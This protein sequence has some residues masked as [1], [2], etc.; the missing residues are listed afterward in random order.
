MLVVLSITS[1]LY[2]E[3]E[4]VLVTLILQKQL[5]LTFL[6]CV[7]P[8]VSSNGLSGR[9]QSHIDYVCLTFLHCAFSNVSS[10]CLPEGMH[11]HTGCNYSISYHGPF[12]S[13]IWKPLFWNYFHPNYHFQNLDPSLISYKTVKRCWHFGCN[14]FYQIQIELYWIER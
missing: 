12:L 2:F 4:M 14:C 9:M 7:F 11:T 5:C 8:N 3:I 6:H 13:L 1:K 10:I